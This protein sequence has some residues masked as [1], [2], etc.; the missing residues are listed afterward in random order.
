MEPI[1]PELRSSGFSFPW[2]PSLSS[3]QKL[4]DPMRVRLAKAA[5]APVVPA[6]DHLDQ[7]SL[8]TK[9]G[10]DL[11]ARAPAVQLFGV[12]CDTFMFDLNICL[13]VFF[14]RK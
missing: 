13:F 6:A 3:T 2:F 14:S 8:V 4:P 10:A 5:V 12:S 9:E 1:F 11:E 7:V